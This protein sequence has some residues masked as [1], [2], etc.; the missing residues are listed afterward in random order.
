MNKSIVRLLCLLVALT[1]TALV[2]QLTSQFVP[3]SSISSR[4]GSRLGLVYAHDNNGRTTAT[5]TANVVAL[6]AWSSH[7]GPKSWIADRMKLDLQGR[8]ALGGATPWTLPVAEG[9]CIVTNGSGSPRAESDYSTVNPDTA[10]I[11]GGTL[12]GFVW[13]DKTQLTGEMIRLT[14]YAGEM[15]HLRVDGNYHDLTLAALIA[16]SANR[17]AVGILMVDD[18]YGIGVGKYHFESLTPNFC[19]VGFKVAEPTAW[20]P[21]PPPHEPPLVF[22]ANV[23]NGDECVVDIFKPEYCD[24]GFLSQ[25]EQCLGMTFGYAAQ[26][27]T[28]VMWK[29]EKGGDF[30]CEYLVALQTASMYGLHITGNDGNMS[31]V[32]E[33]DAVETDANTAATYQV[34][35]IEPTSGYSAANTK[36]GYLKCPSGRVTNPYLFIKN[37]Y[38]MH[39]IE[40]GEFLCQRAIHVEGGLVN[41]FPTVMIYRQKCQVGADF[42]NIRKLFTTASRGY[43]QVVF[44][45]NTEWHAIDGTPVNAGRFYNDFVG[46]INITGDSDV[47]GTGWAIVP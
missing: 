13:V 2:A 24:V 8:V 46:L 41:A 28:P 43:V 23:E 5:G 42:D 21:V 19:V 31:G 29:F 9:V 22:D 37:N 36:I 35:H 39:I 16:D 20:N 34:I 47:Q 10:S 12:T 32:F 7:T 40:G 30:H 11:Q 14:G 45:D 15:G 33:I 6:N 18:K 3:G 26:L 27:N 1:P 44:R 4:T 17:K 38:G 25:H